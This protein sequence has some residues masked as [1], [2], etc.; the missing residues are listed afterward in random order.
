VGRMAVTINNP[1]QAGPS[2]CGIHAC[3]SRVVNQGTGLK[4]PH[5]FPGGEWEADDCEKAVA[6]ENRG[7]HRSQPQSTSTMPRASGSNPRGNL[8]LLLYNAPLRSA[9]SSWASKRLALM[10]FAP[11]KIA[12][13]RSAPIKSERRR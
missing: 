5:S 3:T 2:G 8:V 7:A 12:P 10:R 4:A 9:S 6:A 1:S 11:E 13:V